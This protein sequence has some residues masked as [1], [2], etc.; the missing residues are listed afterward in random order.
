M[1]SKRKEKASRG[2]SK[3][4]PIQESFKEYTVILSFEEN[5]LLIIPTIFPNL[6]FHITNSC[7]QVK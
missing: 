5:R 2:E 1:G 4:I 6:Q 7:S 3:T